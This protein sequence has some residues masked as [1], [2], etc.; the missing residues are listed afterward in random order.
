MGE[1]SQNIN[2]CCGLPV[3]EHSFFEINWHVQSVLEE[4]DPIGQGQSVLSHCRNKMKG[5]TDSSLDQL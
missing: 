5:A 1:D 2:K 3:T 4:Q